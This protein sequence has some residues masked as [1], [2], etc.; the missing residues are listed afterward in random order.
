MLGVHT[1][2][3]YFND[4]SVIFCLMLFY[5]Q[6]SCQLFASEYVFKPLGKH[7]KPFVQI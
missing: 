2:V 3:A 5:A 1:I 7:K 6:I 4:V